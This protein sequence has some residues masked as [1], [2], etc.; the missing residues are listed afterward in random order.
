M[1][2]TVWLS[3]ILMLLCMLA[4]SACDNATIPP[5]SDDSQQKTDE[6]GDNNTAVCQHGFG[7]WNIVKQATCKEEGTRA[8]TCNK[9]SEMEEETTKRLSEAIINVKKKLSQET[10]YK[11][12]E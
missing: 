10:V 6:S 9:C 12:I 1:K 7:G 8:R 3:L 2:K 5:N 11:W 4:L